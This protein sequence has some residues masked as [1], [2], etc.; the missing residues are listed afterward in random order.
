MPLASGLRGQT[1]PPARFS[2]GGS[3]RRRRDLASEPKWGLEP[4]TVSVADRNEPLDQIREMS[5]L[6]LF[7]GALCA[8]F[9]KIPGCGG[10]LLA[11]RLGGISPPRPSPRVGLSLFI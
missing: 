2:Q 8:P 4:T 5:E 3:N 6:S 1:L 10:P 9:E 7:R 11:A